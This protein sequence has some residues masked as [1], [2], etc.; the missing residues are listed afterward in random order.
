MSDAVRTALVAGVFTIT[1][2]RADK[3]NALNDRMY[4]LLAKSLQQAREDTAVRVVLLEAEGVDFCS[5][6]DIADFLH[7]AATGKPLAGAA[8]VNMIAAMVAMDK[9]IVAA[10]QGRAVGIGFTML[11][12]CDLI[13]LAENAELLAPFVRLGLVPEAASSLL[14]PAHIGYVRAFE[15]F[16]LGRSLRAAEA[17][18]LGLAN[19]VV[20][21]AE[22]PAAARTLAQALAAQPPEAL[23]ATKRL[24]RD[25]AALAA[26]TS[27]EFAAFDTRFRSPEAQA[28]FARFADKKG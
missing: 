23:R 24:L 17:L 15:V 20:P 22:L 7:F 6:N 14:L 25:G 8:V 11:L 16:A 5:G 28:V 10:V 21:G 26:A 3:R 27:A 12:H 19:R 9:P 1:L 4:G 2:A 13:C 18:D